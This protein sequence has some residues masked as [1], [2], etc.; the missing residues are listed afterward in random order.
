[1]L[2]RSMDDVT[3]SGYAITMY[4]TLFCLLVPKGSLRICHCGNGIPPRERDGCA[5]LPVGGSDI[6]LPSAEQAHLSV[7]LLVVIV[8]SASVRSID[9]SWGGSTL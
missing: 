4:M 9:D 3:S 1:M 8:D 5:V 7:V 6:A 2:F